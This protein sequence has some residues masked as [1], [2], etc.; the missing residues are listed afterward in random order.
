MTA[1]YKERQR[2]LK[3][4]IQFS[5]I[6]FAPSQSHRNINTSFCFKTQTQK[7]LLGIHET[8]P[9]LNKYNVIRRF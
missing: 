2:Q 4:F 8:I 6:H 9:V 3:S 1:V 7:Y 5:K